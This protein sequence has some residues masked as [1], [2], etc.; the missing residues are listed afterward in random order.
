MLAVNIASVA[1]WWAWRI[2]TMDIFA[3]FL[4]VLIDFF[5]VINVWVTS[6]LHHLIIIKTFIRTK[7]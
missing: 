4:H 6:F 1:Q 7:T 2:A 5:V 3:S